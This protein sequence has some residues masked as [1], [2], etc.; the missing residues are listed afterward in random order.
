MIEKVR[1]DGVKI[2]YFEWCEDL[3]SILPD[4]V[5]SHWVSDQ[6]AEVRICMGI[7]GLM[8]YGGTIIGYNWVASQLALRAFQRGHIDEDDPRLTPTAKIY[9][10]DVYN[11]DPVRSDFVPYTVK[12]HSVLDAQVLAFLLDGGVDNTEPS[13]VRPDTETIVALAQEWTKF[14]EVVS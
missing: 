8:S 11:D 13:D 9:R 14:I 10:I 5:L 6:S 3:I 7:M 1:Q 4:V 2:D 12:A